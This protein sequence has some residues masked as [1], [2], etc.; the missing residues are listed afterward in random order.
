MRLKC[1][2]LYRLPILGCLF[3][4]FFQGC[5]EKKYILSDNKIELTGEVLAY[6]CYG[7]YRVPSYDKRYSVNTG[8]PAVVSFVSESGG[9]Q[10]TTTD[11]SSSF[12]MFV[13]SGMYDVIVETG[14]TFPDTFPDVLITKDTILEFTIYF[15]WFNDDTV[16]VYFVYSSPNDTLGLAVEVEHIKRLN[17][18]IGG[19]FKEIFE[20]R[21]VII[22][23]FPFDT[24]V[25]VR[26]GMPVV[27]GAYVFDVSERSYI[28]LKTP[29]LGFPVGMFVEISFYACLTN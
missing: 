19:D 20:S 24:S 17:Y 26:Y 21:E 1:N 15:N 8:R 6:Y 23:D 10:S 14:H 4:L 3:L 29:E 18:L 16:W 7:E 12:R 9:I 28:L 27:Q 22:Y 25:Y 5:T 11:D 13:D 2:A